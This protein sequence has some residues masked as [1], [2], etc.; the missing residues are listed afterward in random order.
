M[1]I[2]KDEFEDI[3][4]LVV[5]DVMLDEYVWGSVSRISP[6]APVPIVEVESITHTLG[7]AGN[8]V[9]NIVAFGATP[10]ICG[11][12]GADSTGGVLM[13]DMSGANLDISGLI[14]DPTR[15]TT[16]KKRIMGNNYQVT[17]LDTESITKVTGTLFKRIMGFIKARMDEVNIV[18]ISDYNKGIVTTE[19]VRGILELANN[20]AIK[21]ISD[22]QKDNFKCHKYVDLITPNLISVEWY[23]GFKIRSDKALTRA[24]RKLMY[25]LKVGSVIITRG[26]DGMSVFKNKGEVIHIPSVAKKIFDVSGAGDTVISVLSLGLS[27]GLS[28]EEA[29]IMANEA[30]GV[31]V[32]KMGTSTVSVEELKLGDKT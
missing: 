15:P 9:N 23:Y 14:I 30:A 11:L 20:R 22:P 31:A 29:A 13:S 26:E 8:V 27:A 7:G 19:L 18:V 4:V 12:I 1:I 17:R 32:G 3:K 28:L 25:E 6:E 21:V 2:N 24:G 5:G 16:T 10:I